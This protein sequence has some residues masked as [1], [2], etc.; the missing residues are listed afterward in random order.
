MDYLGSNKGEEQEKPRESTNHLL[1]EDEVKC[2][3]PLLKKN[4]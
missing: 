3:K 4:E 1:S 2:Q